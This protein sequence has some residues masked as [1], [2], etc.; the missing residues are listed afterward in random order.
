M[1]AAARCQVVIWV[2]MSP[3]VAATVVSVEVFEESAATV[4]EVL[5]DLE[6]SAATVLDVVEASLLLVALGSVEAVVEVDD[7]D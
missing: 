5:D 7:F 2:L 4:A 6:A 3:V 1:S